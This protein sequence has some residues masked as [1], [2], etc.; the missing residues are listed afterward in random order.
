[1]SDCLIVRRGGGSVPYIP[2]QIEFGSGQQIPITQPGQYTLRG[3][4]EQLAVADV[5]GATFIRATDFDLTHESGQDG[6]GV[7]VDFTNGELDGVTFE[8]FSFNL[9]FDGSLILNVNASIKFKNCQFFG[10]D[11]M[12]M[13]SSYTN[14][15]FESC[16]FG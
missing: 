12:S 16:S 1:M 9:C 15:Y 7:I 6:D 2:G 13:L 8:G 4:I 10:S 5:R 14:I 3:I 11:D